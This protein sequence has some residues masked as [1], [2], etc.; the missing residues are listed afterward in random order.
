VDLE[1]SVRTPIGRAL[2]YGEAYVGS[3]LD[4]GLLIA[5]PVA[6]GTNIREIG[7]YVAYVQEITRYGLV[8]LRVDA[9]D[10][11]GDA[12]TQLGGALLPRDQTITTW[13]P[14]VALV[15]PDRARLLFEYDHILNHEG[16]DWRGVPADLP[17]D[18]LALRLQVEM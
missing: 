1:V 5:D 16:I 12:T 13:S 14:L 11:N 8:G 17:K 6:T 10:P 9:Y 4:R 3:N 7:W 18:Q 15:L 2:V